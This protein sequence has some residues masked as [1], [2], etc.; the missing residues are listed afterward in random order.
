L[1]RIR[2][3]QRIFFAQFVQF[4]AECNPLWPARLPGPRG[5]ASCCDQWRIVDDQSPN[6]SRSDFSRL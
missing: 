4:V 3:I 1:P 6:H 2:R 5:K